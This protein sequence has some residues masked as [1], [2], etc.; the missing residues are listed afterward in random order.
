VNSVIRENN[1]QYFYKQNLVIFSKR[2]IQFLFIMK[3]RNI[4][5]FFILVSITE[6]AIGQQPD[7]L[8]T[9]PANITP[10]AVINRYIEAI[11]G[12]EKFSEI[13]DRTTLINGTAMGQDISIL[14]KQKSPAQFYQE[15][16]AG[17]VIQKMYFDGIRGMMVLGENKTEIAGNELERLKVE[18]TMK[19]LLDPESYGLKLELLQNEI[20]DSI[21]CY[22]IKLTLPSG[23]RTF[24]YYDFNTGLK[25]KELKEI[26][27][28]QGL[29]EQ[30]IFY[31]DYR[32]VQGLKFPFRIRQLFGIQELD[33]EVISLEINTG[34]DESV[35]QLP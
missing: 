24:Q 9:D 11:G 15:I 12:I 10:M 13:E 22:K 30:E 28:P 1:L 26:Q 23:L 2:I 8:E 31:S 35:F 17:E 32:V 29:F 18:S 3:F 16:T 19:L 4:L 14:I 5:L 33:L 25:I 7:T 21:D 27:T 20:V 34:I 6:T